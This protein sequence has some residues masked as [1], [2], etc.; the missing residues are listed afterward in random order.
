MK[1]NPTLFDMSVDEELEK[2]QEEKEEEEKTK[3]AGL[4]EHC[5]AAAV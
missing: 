2:L 4:L 1:E 3:S 5:V